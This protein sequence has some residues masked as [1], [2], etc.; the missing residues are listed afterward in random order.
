LEELIDNVV[1]AIT[2]AIEGGMEPIEAVRAIAV[3]AA[4][5]G[6][7]AY[8]DDAIDQLKSAIEMRRGLPTDGDDGR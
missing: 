3:V 7:A 2:K 5:Y 8:G 1:D 6:R 4:D